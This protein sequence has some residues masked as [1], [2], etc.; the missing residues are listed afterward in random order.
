MTTVLLRRQLE[1][2]LL[3]VGARNAHEM[4]AMGAT[5]GLYTHAVTM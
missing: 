1:T 3:T 5:A 2:N 4:P